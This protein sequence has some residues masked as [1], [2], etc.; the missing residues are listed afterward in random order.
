MDFVRPHAEGREQ[1]VVPGVDRGR[2]CPLRG[3]QAEVLE[4]ISTRQWTKRELH[5]LEV[6]T[7]NDSLAHALER[8]EPTTRELAI[9]TTKLPIDSRSA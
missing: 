4:D 2:R 6:A 3:V 7:L 9:R 5:R 8:L 1:Q